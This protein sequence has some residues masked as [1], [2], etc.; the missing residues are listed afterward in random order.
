MMAKVSQLVGRRGAGQAHPLM[1]AKVGQL[2]GRRGAGQASQE[3][4][5]CDVPC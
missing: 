3:E 1:M 2:V 5:S 4:A